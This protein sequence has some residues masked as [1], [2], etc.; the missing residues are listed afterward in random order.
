[1]S[2][3]IIVKY[4]LPDVFADE[5]LCNLEVTNDEIE[6]FLSEEKLRLLEDSKINEIKK[7]IANKAYAKYMSTMKNNLKD[8]LVIV[9][10]QSLKDYQQEISEIKCLEKRIK[11]LRS[12]IQMIEDSHKNKL[13]LLRK[14]LLSSLEDSLED[15]NILRTPF[16]A[17]PFM[18]GDDRTLKGVLNTFVS[19][20]FVDPLNTKKKDEIICD[21]VL[22]YHGRL[23]QIE[24]DKDVL[25]EKYYNKLINESEDNYVLNCLLVKMR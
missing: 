7:A 13:D 21:L 20:A 4:V 12:E 6:I 17:G 14:R 8:L 3:E 15:K 10:R 1:M 18:R 22:N 16:T 19:R 9:E 23:S 5:L 24:K 11:E 25:V 2:K